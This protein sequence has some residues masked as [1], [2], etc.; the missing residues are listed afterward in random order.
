[1]TAEPAQTA[2]ALMLGRESKEL[3]EDVV[4]PIT[5]FNCK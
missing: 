3:G 4:V 1:M 5:V 2:K